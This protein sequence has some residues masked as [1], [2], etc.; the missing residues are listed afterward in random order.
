MKHVAL[1]ILIVH[2]VAICLQNVRRWFVV[3]VSVLFLN[4]NVGVPILL[5]IVYSLTV[6]KVY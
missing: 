5:L 3:V 6:C 2:L 1:V 4:K